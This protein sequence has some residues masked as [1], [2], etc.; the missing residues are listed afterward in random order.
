MDINDN[1]PEFASDYRPVIYE[2][3]E[4]GV[5]VATISAIDRDVATNGP[6]FEFWIPCRGACPCPQNPTCDDFDFR[7]IPGEFTHTL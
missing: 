1:Y 5:T 4:P 7:F 2:N 6:P 3:M